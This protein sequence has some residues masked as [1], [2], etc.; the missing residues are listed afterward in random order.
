MKAGFGR[1]GRLKIHLKVNPGIEE[2]A[3]NNN[4]LIFADVANAAS[5]EIKE[6]RRRE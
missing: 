2:A 6:P 3:P 5:S 1:V 4:L